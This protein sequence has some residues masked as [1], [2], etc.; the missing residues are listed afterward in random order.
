MSKLNPR[1]PRIWPVEKAPTDSI[2]STEFQVLKP[3]DQELLGFIYFLL[4]SSNAR[5]E[6]TMAASGTSGSHQRVRPED[7]LNITCMLPG[8]KLLVKFSE[9]TGDVL[10]K[11][12][13]NLTQI[14][15]LEKLRDN[16]LPKLM[17]G[18][19]RVQYE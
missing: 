11:T 10:A 4:T 12:E 14:R 7:I 19:V 15:T 13:H 16:L 6:L 9:I 17:S 5:D 8:P 1:F 2:C 18:E 3:N